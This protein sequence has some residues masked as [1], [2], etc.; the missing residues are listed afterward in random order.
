MALADHH[1]GSESSEPPLVTQTP[2]STETISATVVRA[3]AA[4]DGRPV[5]TLP[6]LMDA[7]DPDALDALFENTEFGEMAFVYADHRIV[8][9]ADPV[10]AVY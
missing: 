7:V 8:V 9:S 5:E 3:V 4:V 6:P 1:I 2:E 10:V